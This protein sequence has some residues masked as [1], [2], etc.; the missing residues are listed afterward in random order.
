VGDTFVRN[1]ITTFAVP[2]GFSTL[3]LRAAIAAAMANALSGDTIADFAMLRGLS[4]P[5]LCATIASTMGE[6]LVGNSS[7]GFT[8]PC[9]G[10]APLFRAAIAIFFF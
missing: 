5:I 3:I 2:D 6:A 8:N 9:K 7:T 10:D 1:T 4:T